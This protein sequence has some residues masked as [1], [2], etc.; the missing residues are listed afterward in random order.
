M[1]SNCVFI[2]TGLNQPRKFRVLI[3]FSLYFLLTHSVG[4][5]F[6]VHL[7]VQGSD[8]SE[9][10][11]LALLDSDVKRGTKGREIATLLPTVHLVNSETVPGK[12]SRAATVRAELLGQTL[13]TPTKH[14]HLKQLLWRDPCVWAWGTI[15]GLYGLWVRWRAGLPKY[16][17]SMFYEN[18]LFSDLL[19]YR[20]RRGLSKNNSGDWL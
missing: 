7:E 1:W 2:Q 17:L 5:W 19:N 20:N 18:N 12:L 8:R 13:P 3:W 10:H 14:R 9:G 15:L 11:C 4:A 16:F 6:G